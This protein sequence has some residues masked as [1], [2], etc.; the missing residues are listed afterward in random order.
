MLFCLYGDDRDAPI[1]EPLRLFHLNSLQL[2]CVTVPRDAKG[3]VENSGANNS[4]GLGG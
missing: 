4:L 3:I 1:F 2:Q